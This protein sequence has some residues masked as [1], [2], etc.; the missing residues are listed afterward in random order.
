V[1]LARAA[2]GCSLSE[3][4][5]VKRGQKRTYHIHLGSGNILMERGGE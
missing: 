2:L 3:Q 5:L 4:F 1:A